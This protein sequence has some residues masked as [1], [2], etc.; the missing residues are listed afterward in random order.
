MDKISKFSDSIES[1]GK[2]RVTC[3]V[4]VCLFVTVVVV[5]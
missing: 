5:S 3:F 4:V 1:R 2:N